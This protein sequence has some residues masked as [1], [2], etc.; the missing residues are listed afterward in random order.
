MAQILCKECGAENDSNTRFC[1]RCDA[2]LDWEENAPD[3]PEDQ[4]NT[5][6]TTPDDTRP[7]P[8]ET[9][10]G[11]ARPP[12]ITPTTTTATLNGDTG[13]QIDI[14][15]RNRSTI[16]DAFRIDIIAPP[17][18]LTLNPA[19][20]RVLPSESGLLAAAFRIQPDT[21]VIAQTV[22]VVIRV[23]SQRDTD[24]Y[25]DANMSLTI[26]PAGPPVP[27]K[28]QP[29]V[30][31][32]VDQTEGRA[33]ILLDNTE[34]NYPRT[35]TLTGS[36]DQAALGFLF[37]PPQLEIG[38]GRV[39]EAEI[40]FRAPQIT[41]GTNETH[42]ALITARE[43]ENTTTASLTI[44]QQRSAVLPL[45]TRLEP[46]V[47]RVTDRRDAQLNLIIDNRNGR[48]DRRIDLHGRDPEGVIQFSF[49][50]PTV[51]PA[52]TTRTRSPTTVHRRRHRSNPRHRSIR[53]TG[54]VHLTATK[55]TMGANPHRCNRSLRR[56][57]RRRTVVRPRNKARDRHRDEH[58]DNSPHHHNPRNN[59][60]NHT[61]IAKHGV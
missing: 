18:W 3:R 9:S 44:N 40:Q 54:P 8:A 29:S 59:T 14:E 34:S 33:Q 55:V 1:V 38:P 50:Q 58:L 7:T 36:D 23:T 20:V 22:N 27:I 46:S 26:P 15:V 35:I 13:A 25:V 28:V 17:R 31:R 21:H 10:D 39:G 51:V 49:A 45:Q 32:L 11:A 61:P 37:S 41:E 60:T 47:V 53:N 4:H 56:S 57:T 6:A 24:Q 42:T 52:A 16:V 43:G 12:Q 48:Q 30:V 19:E 2:Y 5:P